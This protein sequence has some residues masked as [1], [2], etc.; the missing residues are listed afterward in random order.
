MQ[1][2]ELRKRALTLAVVCVEQRVEALRA[3]WRG[4]S[5]RE[6]AQQPG[7]E[8][9]ILDERAALAWLERERD[10]AYREAVTA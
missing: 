3:E 7:L 8:G 10:A 6:R 1:T 4:M 5:E 2:T 9:Q